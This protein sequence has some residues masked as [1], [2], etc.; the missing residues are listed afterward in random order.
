[1]FF[2]ENPELVDKNS[3]IYYHKYIPLLN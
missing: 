3:I 1:M 2:D